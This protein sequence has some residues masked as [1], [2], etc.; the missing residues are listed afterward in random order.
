MFLLGLVI[1]AVGAGLLV[2]MWARKRE[3]VMRRELAKLMKAAAQ[4]QVGHQA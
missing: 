2:F 4:A 1:G 3:K